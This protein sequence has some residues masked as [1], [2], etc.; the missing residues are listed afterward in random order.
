MDI[1]SKLWVIVP[2]Y[3]EEASIVHV[4]EEWM[5]ELRRNVGKGQFVFCTLNDGSKDNTSEILHE[6]SKKY[7]EI[8]VIDKQNTGHGQTCVFGYR[9]AL[10]NNAEWIFQI[11][12]DGQCDP[13]FF[14]LFWN[15][16]N[17]HRIIYGFRT[18]RDDGFSRFLIS[19]VVTLVVFFATG[20]FVRD[21][22]VPYR[23]MH[24][25]TLKDVIQHIPHDFKLSNIL[26]AA[27]QKRL[28]YIKW[29]SITFRDRYGGSPSVKTYSF[30]KEGLKLHRQLKVFCKSTKYRVELV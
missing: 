25:S 19:R 24:A 15:Q 5:P 20:V 21:A 12:S 14:K 30:M 28:Y 1:P 8:V 11:D 22:N 18:K 29:V 2:V 4:V 17:R 13:S 27:V 3:N 26:L 9:E 23:L 16:R 6:Q 7:P 10:M